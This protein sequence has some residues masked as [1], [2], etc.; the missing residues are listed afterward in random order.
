MSTG[1][2]AP[3]AAPVNRNEPDEVD[4]VA[5]EVTHRH[6]LNVWRY[7][8]ETAHTVAERTVGTDGGLS[9]A[10]VEAGR[11]IPRPA[12]TDE[13]GEFI[14]NL[15]RLADW[16]EANPDVPLPRF[17]ELQHTALG[18]YASERFDQVEE[19]AALAGVEPIA[20]RHGG[21]ITARKSFGD[22]VAYV[23][24]ASTRP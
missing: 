16:L 14:E 5:F 6:A 7:E 22:R 11:A 10:L 18:G 3:G 20:G 15:R 23:A 9:R 21:T 2:Y 1:T 13:R 4:R 17:A 12:P 19:I 24:F 8:G